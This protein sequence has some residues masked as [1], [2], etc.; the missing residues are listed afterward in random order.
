[1][2]WVWN[3]VHDKEDML[4]ILQR[5]VFDVVVIDLG[6]SEADAEKAILG[7]KQIRPSLVGCILVLNSQGAG[8]QM[9]ELIE[10]HDLIQL[11]QELLPAHLWTILEEC[12]T[13]PRLREL[14]PRP[15]PVARLIF[16]SLRQPLSAGVRTL[17]SWARLL[18]YQD[19]R[20]IIDLFVDGGH[21]I[22]RMRLTGQVLARGNKGK[23]ADLSVVLVNRSGTLARTT[24]NQ[25]GEFHIECEFPEDLSLQI[26]LGERT[27]VLVP[28]GEMD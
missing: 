18:A 24:T 15:M 3:V 12:V 16:D 14:A 1:M 11:S 2:G 27:W 20:T 9:L 28:L 21:E 5:E 6:C 19:E 22:G 26:R 13:S 4:A 10:R 8:R 7:I 25:F 23:I 17:S